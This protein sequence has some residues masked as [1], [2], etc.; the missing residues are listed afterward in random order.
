MMW[1][2]KYGMMSGSRAGTGT[3]DYGA[4]MGG[5]MGGRA[6]TAGPGGMM[7]QG[8]M[9]SGMM[10]SHG[11]SPMWTPGTVEGPVSA[12]QAQQL[13]NTWLAEQQGG[14]VTAGAPDALPGYFTMETMKNGKIDGMISVNATTGAVFYHW[15]HGSFI[16]MEE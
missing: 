16:A 8:G 6:G 12:A 10:G 13:A 9:M 11:G 15:W 7:G 3:G 2:T 5:M 4:G 1:N 14:S